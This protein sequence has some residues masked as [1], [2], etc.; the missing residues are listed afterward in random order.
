MI[1]INEISKNSL[2]KGIPDSLTIT[3]LNLCPVQPR[4]KQVYCKSR[5]QSHQSAVNTSG[6]VHADSSVSP[7]DISDDSNDGYYSQSQSGLQAT[8]GRSDR[9]ASLITAVRLY[10]NSPPEN[11]AS[12]GELR[13]TSSDYLA[14]PLSLSATFWRPDVA[15][16]WKEQEETYSKYADLTNVARDIFSIIHHGIGVESSCSL[17]RDVI[18]W[19]QT[20]KTGDSLREQVVVRQFARSNDGVLAGDTTDLKTLRSGDIEAQKATE[21]KKLH[22]LAKVHDFLDMWDG[23]EKLQHMQRAARAH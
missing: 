23:S 5:G 9:A 16:W 2:I 3:T 12:W 11:L 1:N 10:L 19:R 13:P 14:D 15:A 18:G 7:Y 17:G 4:D 22:R 21:D 8:P 6:S 20:R